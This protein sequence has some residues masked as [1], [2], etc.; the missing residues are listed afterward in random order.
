MYNFMNERT[1]LG[2]DYIDSISN[3]EIWNKTKESLK[4]KGLELS[5]LPIDVIADMLITEFS[6]FLFEFDYVKNRTT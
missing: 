3:D 5:N 4:G 1:W 6:M 2:N